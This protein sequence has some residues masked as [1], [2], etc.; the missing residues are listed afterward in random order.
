MGRFWSVYM[1]RLLGWRSG[2]NVRWWVALQVSVG[3]QYAVGMAQGEGRRRL[4]PKTTR[5]GFRFL[6]TMTS[7]FATM[8]LVDLF[9]R[10]SP[11]WEDANYWLI[12]WFASGLSYWY[13]VHSNY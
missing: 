8:P 2:R 1:G 4:E 5:G 9:I 3:Q 6:M 11:A 10:P 13:G 7:I 12:A